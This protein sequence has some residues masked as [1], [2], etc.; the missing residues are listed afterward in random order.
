MKLPPIFRP[1]SPEESQRFITKMQPKMP[2]IFKQTK[3]TAGKI[4]DALTGT[5]SAVVTSPLAAGEAALN[6]SANTVGLVPTSMYAIAKAMDVTRQ[7]IDSVFK[8]KP[9]FGGGGSHDSHGGGHH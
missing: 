2:N 3:E 7:K 6:L 1:P 4:W 9:S 8:F 5:A